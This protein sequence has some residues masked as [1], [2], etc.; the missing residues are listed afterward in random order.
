MKT[1]KTA[2]L[3]TALSLLAL[4]FLPAA[5]AEQLRG[6]WSVAPSKKPGMV[7]FGI[8]YRDDEGQSQHQSDWPVASLQGL[9]LTTPDRHDVKFAVLREAGR[10]DGEGFVNAGEGAGTL[11]FTPDPDY[12]PAMERLG[13][14]DIDGHKQFAMAIHDVTTDFAR[15]MK[16][17]KLQG[18][19]TDKLIA[20]RIFGVTP[21]FIDELRAAGLRADEADKL[22]AFRVHGVTPAVVRELGRLGLD[23]DEDQLVAFRVHGVTPEYVTQVKAAGLGQP[24]AD[25][26][27]AMRVHG[28]TP[29]YIARMK[30]RG[31]KNL[32]LE[33]LVEL[34]VHGID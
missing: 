26:L 22:V 21:Q 5:A 30:S 19:D 11:R 12:A 14:D 28:V 33:R 27:I 34:K 23:L 16:A 10:L 17:Q 3:G 2:V 6:H 7:M 15:T 25:H 24:D 20:F 1:L 31:L 8:T 29:E 13:F 4:G 32:T 9:D 18:L